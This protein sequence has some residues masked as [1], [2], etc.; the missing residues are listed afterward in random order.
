L[1]QFHFEIRLFVSRTPNQQPHEFP[2]V[3]LRKF[4]SKKA[5]IWNRMS[6]RFLVNK[7]SSRF[8]AQSIRIP[9]SVN[10]EFFQSH[11]AHAPAEHAQ[12]RLLCGLHFVLFLLDWL[13]DRWSSR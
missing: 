13:V 8:L 6:T 10:T 1:Q 5:W 4:S 3:G 9:R 7:P 11:Y 12:E 2:F